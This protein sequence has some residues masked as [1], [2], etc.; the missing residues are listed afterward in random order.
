MAAGDLKRGPGPIWPKSDRSV[1]GRQQE[2]GHF[3]GGVQEGV[4]GRPAERPGKAWTKRSKTKSERRTLSRRR[5]P[6]VTRCENTNWKFRSRSKTK[7]T[8]RTPHEGSAIVS[9]CRGCN[10]KST[11]ATN[12]D[13]LLARVDRECDQRKLWVAS[14]EHS[15]STRTD[16]WRISKSPRTPQPQPQRQKWQSMIPRQKKSVQRLI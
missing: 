13:E 10:L 7:T 9:W 1:W 4:R 6:K 16:R 14:C 2:R 8:H 5:R 11:S 15:R 12:D 3:W